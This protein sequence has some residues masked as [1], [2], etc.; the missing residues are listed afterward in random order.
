[1]TNAY[2]RVLSCVLVVGLFIHFSLIFLFASPL[3]HTGKKIEYLSSFYC[4][5]YFQQSWGL[6]V[7]AP[8][9][10]HQLFVRYKKQNAWSNWFDILQ[11]EYLKHRNNRLSG[12]ETT[13]LLLSNSAHYAFNVLPDAQSVYSKISDKKELQVL[14]YEI[15]QYLKTSED[16]KP[17]TD[18]EI[19]LVNQKQGK[20]TTNYFKFLKI[21]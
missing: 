17:N 3:K 18:Y 12:G 4:Y 21:N 16:L 8:N 11:K 5:P 7:P 10:Q 15:V 1:M 20:I 9:A 6:F 13:V 14:N 19:L 2:K